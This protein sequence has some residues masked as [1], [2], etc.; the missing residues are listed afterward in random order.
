MTL[1]LKGYQKCRNSKLKVQLLLSKVA[2]PYLPRFMFGLDYVFK[3]EGCMYEL[4]LGI[5]IPSISGEC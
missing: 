5:N 3:D 2:Q 1:Y 4:G